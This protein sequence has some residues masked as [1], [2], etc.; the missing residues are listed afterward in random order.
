MTS[1]LVIAMAA[2]L[3]YALTIFQVPHEL[4]RLLDTMAPGKIL[5]LLFVQPEES[6]QR[7]GAGEIELL[8]SLLQL[9]V[10]D[11]GRRRGRQRLEEPEL[12]L[13]LL[14]GGKRGRHRHGDRDVDTL[15]LTHGEPAEDR[16]ATGQH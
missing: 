15:I 1:L 11:L 8:Q 9:G 14:L 7:R 2:M 6:L 5:F 12:R 10:R 13:L 3:G 16:C 4:G